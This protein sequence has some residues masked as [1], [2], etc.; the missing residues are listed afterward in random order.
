MK[1]GKQF[2]K[3]PKFIVDKVRNYRDEW[4]IDIKNNDGKYTKPNL[5]K[6]LFKEINNNSG[7]GVYGLNDIINYLKNNVIDTIIVT[8]TVN[9]DRIESKCNRCKNINEKIVERQKMMQTKIEFEG[10]PCSSC[11]SLDI[12]VSEQDIVDYFSLLGA[13]TGTKIEVISG[14]AEHGSMVSNL[15]NIGAILRYNPNYSN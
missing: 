8:D 11:K 3:Q 2:S 5:R 9:L 13:K 10:S 6:K 4:K 14:V 12:S 1:K 7:L 15:G